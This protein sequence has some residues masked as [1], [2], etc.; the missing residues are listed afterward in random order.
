MK[1]EKVYNLTV[2]GNEATVDNGIANST[3]F[4]DFTTFQR[5]YNHKL[6]ESLTDDD[7]YTYE[8]I[9]IRDES[10]KNGRRDPVAELQFTKNSLTAAD[11]K[12]ACFYR[13]PKL[14]LP[15]AKMQLLKEKY[16]AKVIRNKDKADYMITS[17]KYLESIFEYDWTGVNKASEMITEWL[18]NVKLYVSESI[19]DKLSNFL[20]HVSKQ[21]AYVVFQM[22][23]HWN[24]EN[25]LKSQLRID[26]NHALSKTTKYPYYIKS[27]STLNYI[28]NN[29]D[30]VCLDSEIIDFC[31]EDSV[32]LTREDCASI[33]KMIKSDDSVNIALALEMMAN[34]NIEKSYDKIALI[35]AFYDH[36]LRYA[37]NWNTVNVKSL[38]KYMHGVKP[39]DVDRSGH[40]YNVLI[41]HL[42]KKNALN[43]FTLGAISN[44]MCKTILKNIGLTHDT[45]VFDLKPKDLKLKEVYNQGMD[46]PF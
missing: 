39:V 36:L 40:G 3:E 8:H 46:L 16:N 20:N 21:D 13:T 23:W 29:K 6:I 25:K 34:C 12:D 11:L 24:F 32:I 14:D 35:F 17:R 2:K 4:L 43:N 27:F 9:L 18:P 28:L 42:H 5:T 10:I 30:I 33:A 37:S 45:S 41:K 38:R 22:T 31:N 19:Y 44:K 15:Q 7:G 26:S 1:L